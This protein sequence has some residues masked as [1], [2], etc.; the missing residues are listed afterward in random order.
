[1]ATLITNGQ[2]APTSKLPTTGSTA[3]ANNISLSTTSADG[4][5]D[6]TLTDGQAFLVSCDVEAR[7]RIRDGGSTVTAVTTDTRLPANQIVF[8]EPSR[9]NA[10]TRIAG[11]LASGTGTLSVTIVSLRG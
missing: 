5:L 11:I 8:L 3:N 2:F 7:I 1:M 10:T 6:W 4:S 9:Y